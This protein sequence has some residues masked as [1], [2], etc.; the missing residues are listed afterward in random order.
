MA[1]SGGIQERFLSGP[2]SRFRIFDREIRERQEL[3]LESSLKKPIQTKNILGKIIF[4]RVGNNNGR[5]GG[6][7]TFFSNLV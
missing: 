5:D 3:S 2:E 6:A 4:L 1:G 7:I